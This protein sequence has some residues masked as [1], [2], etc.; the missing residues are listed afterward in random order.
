MRFYLVKY[1]QSNLKSR[2]K[3]DTVIYMLLHTRRVY[4]GNFYR[5]G[6]KLAFG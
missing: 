1:D 6:S 3:T 5:G 2:Y 4:Q